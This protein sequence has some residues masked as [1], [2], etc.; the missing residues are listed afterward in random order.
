MT[1]DQ[2]CSTHYLDG[3]VDLMDLISDYVT[4]ELVILISWNGTPHLMP[5]WE[6]DN[7]YAFNYLDFS[8][9]GAT[10]Q[11]ALQRSILLLQQCAVGSCSQTTAPDINN[12]WYYNFYTN[13]FMLGLIPFKALSLQLSR[14]HRILDFKVTNGRN[15]VTSISKKKRFFHVHL[16]KK[17]RSQIHKTTQM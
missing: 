3:T 13:D 16:R 10:G 14:T 8:W 5:S 17:Q 12:K 1:Y 6:S 2:A 4:T 7:S 9:R 15:E 11:P